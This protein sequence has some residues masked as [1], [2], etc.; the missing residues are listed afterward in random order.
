[1]IKPAKQLGNFEWIAT[2]AITVPEQQQLMDDYGIT[3]DIITYVTDKDESAN[4]V[5]DP[6]NNQQLLIALVPYR[7]KGEKMRYIAR[8]VGFLIHRGRIFTFNDSNLDFIDEALEKA[9][10]DDEVTTPASFILEALFAFIDSYIPIIK[11]VTK[12]RN[13]LDK[14][15]NRDPKNNMLVDLSNLGQTLTFFFSGVESNSDLFVR[16]PR[17]YFGVNNSSYERDQL[18]DVAIEADQVRRMIENESQVVDRIIN[19][20]DSIIN[21]NLNDTM[22]FLTIWSLT[23]AVPTIVT[24]FYGMNVKL[25]LA[26]LHDAWLFVV[27]LSLAA[28]VWLLLTIKF[29]HKP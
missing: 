9:F 19:T 2:S 27:G 5:Y 25:P 13:Q 8:P 23:M 6:E 22:R 24:G 4:Y 7:L 28:I 29:H 10:V 3:D 18:E 11:Q 1:M 16:I 15:L 26:G 12:Q 21:N 14:Q 17:T 20:F